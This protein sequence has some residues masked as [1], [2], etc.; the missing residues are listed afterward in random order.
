MAKNQKKPVGNKARCRSSFVV[1]FYFNQ[2]TYDKAYQMFRAKNDDWEAAD[3]ENRKSEFDSIY[4]SC[5]NPQH[6]NNEGSIWCRK[7]NNDA[8]WRLNKPCVVYHKPEGTKDRTPNP[9]LRCEVAN[10]GVA[11]FK[12]GI[13]FLWYEIAVQPL[14]F[15]PL[16]RWMGDKEKQAM[17]ETVAS[18]KRLTEGNK[19]ALTDI[20]T[21]QELQKQLEERKQWEAELSREEWEKR[22]DEQLVEVINHWKDICHLASEQN[23]EDASKSLLRSYQPDY[24]VFLP[25]E[26]D[27]SNAFHIYEWIYQ[28]LLLDLSGIEKFTLRFFNPRYTYQ[29]EGLRKSPDKANVFAKLLDKLRSEK[30]P[31][32]KNAEEQ[33]PDKAHVFTRLRFEE[34]PEEERSMKL[35]Y[36]T[37]KG[38]KESYQA[39]PGELDPD[40][41]DILRT[42]ESVI[43]GCSPQ[44]CSVIEHATGNATTDNFFEK[45]WREDISP[46]FIIYLVCLQQFYF[47]SKLSVEIAELPDWGGKDAIKRM[48]SIRRRLDEGYARMF[49]PR[50]SFEDHYNKLYCHIRETLQITEL[51]EELSRKVGLLADLMEEKRAEDRELRES[52]LTIIGGVFVVVQTA[53]TVLEM[54]D[55]MPKAGAWEAWL[56]DRGRFALGM[57][58]TMV[59]AGV[60]IALI[61]K[62]ITSWG[63]KDD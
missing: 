17:L 55:W 50:I 34:K 13:G 3:L 21:D 9:Y 4:R 56:D 25:V 35:L 20:L 19:K 47:M 40:S 22:E 52:I 45:K 62:W 36:W 33:G 43:W 49:F 7:G 24:N 16:I 6:S 60:L 53:A 1:P 12:T 37:R 18:Q 30:K 29:T 58:P 57:L 54:S 10:C 59:I 44:G 39:A 42:F 32:A 14:P 23:E 26:Q 48:K 11:I 63:K 38:Y 27:G 28:S 15:F 51:Q 8:A 2:K 61:R 46:D 41:P 31:E 5:V